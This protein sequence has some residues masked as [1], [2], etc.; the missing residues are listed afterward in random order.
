MLKNRFAISSAYFDQTSPCFIFMK[1]RRGMAQRINDEQRW[2]DDQLAEP[3]ALFDPVPK[4]HNS[5][6]GQRPRLGQ[7]ISKAKLRP[8]GG[9]PK[10][11]STQVCVRRVALH[12]E[13]KSVFDSFPP[14]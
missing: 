11:N 3:G 10:Q 6:N 13:E 5:Y 1:S 14:S 7:C 12:G 9:A 8:E 2:G 4:Y